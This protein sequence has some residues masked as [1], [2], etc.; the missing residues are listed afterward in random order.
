MR[1]YVFGLVGIGLLSATCAAAQEAIELNNIYPINEE[2]F[3]LPDSIYFTQDNLGYFEVIAGPF[4]EGPARCIGGGFGQQNGMNSIAGI[5]IFGEGEDTFTMTWKAGEQGAA[6]RWIIV[7]GT[8]RY[9]GMTGQGIATT[10]VNVMYH[11]QPRRKSH[12]TGTVMIP[13][14]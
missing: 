11:A 12:I 8:G 6:N 7:S 2:R 5:C 13:N 1:R 9:D 3:Q 4:E 14:R 10:G